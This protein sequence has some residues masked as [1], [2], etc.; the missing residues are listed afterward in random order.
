MRL[1]LFLD[2]DWPS[3]DDAP[4]E[5]VQLTRSSVV[6]LHSRTQPSAI[7]LSET[8]RAENVWTEFL[9]LGMTPTVRRPNLAAVFASGETGEVGDLAR[10]AVLRMRGAEIP[11]TVLRARQGTFYDR[12]DAWP[13]VGEQGDLEAIRH[14]LR[15]LY[16]AFPELHE[17]IV[18]VG[19]AVA[20]AKATTTAMCL[21]DAWARIESL[22]L[23]HPEIVPW[24]A[25]PEKML[26]TWVGRFA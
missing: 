7:A 1:F 23:A 21:S 20:R 3:Y 2:P 19:Q 16:T 11:T 9:P 5:L 26:G 25:G 12:V 18:P 13:H 8:L 14:V 10:T 17:A 24:L 4:R 22:R 15:G 6:A